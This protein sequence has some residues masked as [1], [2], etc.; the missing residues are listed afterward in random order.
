MLP[1]RLQK[2]RYYGFLSRHSKLSID[3]IRHDII[4]SLRDIEPD[5]ELEDWKV[6]SLR[7]PY[8]ADKDTRPRC[9]TCGGRLIFESFHRTRP[10]PLEQRVTHP[11]HGT[12]RR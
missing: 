11:A 12:I 8:H 9:P 2:T 4:E 1:S 3:D 6:P 10:P 5:L 7:P